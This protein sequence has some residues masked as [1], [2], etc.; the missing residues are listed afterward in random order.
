MIRTP[1][2]APGIPSA[3]EKNGAANMTAPTTLNLSVLPGALVSAITIVG[4]IA[5]HL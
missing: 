4:V 5:E 1:G 2:P 3:I